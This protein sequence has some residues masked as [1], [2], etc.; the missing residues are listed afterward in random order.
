MKKLIATIFLLPS[1]AISQELTQFENGKVA[2]ADKINQNFQVLKNAIEN[3]EVAPT[4]Q[5]RDKPC[6]PILAE[7]L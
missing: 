4:V 3:I 7:S 6:T 1:L 2:D 5:P